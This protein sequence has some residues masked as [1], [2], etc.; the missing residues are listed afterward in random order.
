LAG[1]LFYR[2]DLYAALII[3]HFIV[4]ML[5]VLAIATN[6]PDTQVEKILSLCD[7]PQHRQP[8]D[9]IFDSPAPT[10]RANSSGQLSSINA[11][12]SS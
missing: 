2:S 12:A 7:L 1:R 9:A 4:D 5:T 6:A 11:S 10:A 8:F 3:K